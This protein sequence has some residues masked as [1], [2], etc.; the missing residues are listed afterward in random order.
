MTEE[1]GFDG[2]VIS[3]FNQSSTAPPG[4]KFGQ[5]LGGEKYIIWTASLLRTMQSHTA[6][7]IH[8]LLIACK[9]GMA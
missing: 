4:S 2:F 1:K 8:Y 6:F 5:L 7:I 9:T 3:H